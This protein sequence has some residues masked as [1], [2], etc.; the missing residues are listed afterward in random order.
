MSETINL[1]TISIKDK[2]IFD[3]DELYKVM[4]RWLDRE[5]YGNE[6]KNF[7]E[8]LYVERIKGDSKQ[9][10]IRWVGEKIG[11]DYFSNRIKIN[12]LI[13]NLKEIEIEID[14]KKIPMKKGQIKL[15]I[16]SDLVK[17]RQNKWQSDF[18]RKI[19]EN[20][21]VNKRIDDYWGYYY[22]KTNSFI[23]EIKEFLELRRA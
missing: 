21:I 23:D 5:G 11:S 18:F 8:E 16:K 12:F 20:T 10:E 9:I 7:K 4:K 17:D 22:G 2:G 19:Y 13:I 6:E 1:V 3:L 15:D 14:G